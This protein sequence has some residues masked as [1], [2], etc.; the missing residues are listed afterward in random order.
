MMPPTDRDSSISIDLE[1]AGIAA[2][3][4]DAL[5]P[6][7]EITDQ[8]ITVTVANVDGS[9]ALIVSS[10][11]NEMS[12]AHHAM[13]CLT[14]VERVRLAHALL[15]GI[16]DEGAA[17]QVANWLSDL[18]GGWTQY[19]INRARGFATHLRSLLNDWNGP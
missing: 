5:G 11:D 10:R 13:S 12:A 14:I 7:A 17:G 4:I 16:I 15:S 2:A 19:E 3:Q 6:M 9:T 18:G 1:N 8:I